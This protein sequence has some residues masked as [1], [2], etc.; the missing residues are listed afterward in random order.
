MFQIQLA[1]PQRSNGNGLQK[2][3]ERHREIA[4]LLYLGYSN[5][6]IAEMV[7]MAET[8]ISQIKNSDLMKAHLRAMQE[9][10][11]EG[12]MAVLDEFHRLS[13]IAVGVF[14]EVMSNTAAKHRDR[15]SAASEIL[16]RAGYGAVKKV[17]SHQVVTHLTKDDID[18]IKQRAIN[19]GLVVKSTKTA[20]VLDV[21]RS[22]G[23]APGHSEDTSD[24]TL[25]SDTSETGDAREA[26]GL[27]S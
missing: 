24:G 7:G 4:R 11:D 2:L 15:M 10:S 25:G 19:E 6:K 21:E 8:S 22:N 16:D 13:P 14:R 18:A 23:D 9:R 12:A 5:Q 17:D 3:Q 20:N 26:D 27:Q 1:K